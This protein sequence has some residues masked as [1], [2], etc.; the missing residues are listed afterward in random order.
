MQNDRLSP[1]N[2]RGMPTRR[3]LTSSSTAAPLDQRRNGI[4]WQRLRHA[5]VVT[6]CVAVV[7]VG[8]AFVAAAIVLLTI[9]ADIDGIAVGY[10]VAT[11]AD[12]DV[13]VT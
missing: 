8:A 10:V 3:P 6:V 11:A 1:K 12:D 7:F 2:C 9:D 13:D 5:N 4:F